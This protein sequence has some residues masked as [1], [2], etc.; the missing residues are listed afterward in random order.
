[1]S[2]CI[3]RAVAVAALVDIKDPALM[4]N[5]LAKK[6]IPYANNL[7]VEIAAVLSTVLN[8]KYLD[9]EIYISSVETEIS[10]S[11]IILFKI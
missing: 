4:F 3:A 5:F 1:M 7:Q 9:T 8:K 10:S 2:Y 11:E 6:T